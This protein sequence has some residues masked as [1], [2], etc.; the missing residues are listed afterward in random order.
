MLD[1]V[2][3]C[4]P[5]QLLS[6]PLPPA[7]RRPQPLPPREEAL[8]T[9]DTMA[10]DK[11]TVVAVHSVIGD[12][13]VDGCGERGAVTGVVVHV[14]LRGPAEFL[15]AVEA[16][17]VAPAVQVVQFGGCEVDSLPWLVALLLFFTVDDDGFWNIGRRGVRVRPTDTHSGV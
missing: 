12:A 5:D 17:N 14:A 2:G 16:R 10:G 7:L 13:V 11:V 3:L 9:W 6:P 4:I 1:S 15:G 8:G